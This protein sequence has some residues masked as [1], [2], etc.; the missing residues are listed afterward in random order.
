MSTAITTGASPP[1]PTAAR[2]V[3]VPR[4]RLEAVIKGRLAKPMRV[5]VYGIEGVGKSTFAAG[6]PK[7]IFL[8][9]EDGTSEL[10]VARFPEPRSWGD[11]LDALDVLM[12]DAHDYRTLVV[13]TLDWLEPL[14]WQHACETGR[15]KFG[16][17]FKTIED[18]GYGKGYVAALLLWRE[19][20]KRFELLREARSMHLV[21][22]AHSWIKPFKNPEGED[23]DRYEMKLDKRAASL[24]REQCDAVLF[25]THETL[26]YESNGRTKGISS[27]A[28]VL[29]TQRRA[30]W[31]AKNRY[32][33][34]EALPLDWPAFVDAVITRRPD[35]PE[36][37]KARI[38]ATLAAAPAGAVDV[39]AVKRVTSAAGDNA[40]ELARILNKLSARVSIERT[41]TQQD[42]AP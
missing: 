10:D 25:A 38:E 11:A 20:I 26:T 21:M 9:A 40:A 14:V 6:S 2:A 3:T 1:Q 42:T 15:D 32:D 39:E 5:L 4:M 19:W 29:Q 8:G 30:A 12:S 22:L 13:D 24:L 41:N 7:P 17:P 34:P 27:G 33:L 18:F 36:R 37:I 16:K 31:D 28:R 35:D 23:F